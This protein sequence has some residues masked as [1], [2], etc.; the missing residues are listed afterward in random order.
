MIVTFNEEY[1]RDIYR[2]GVCQDKR[3]LYQPDIIRRYRKAVAYMMA[4]SSPEALWKIHSLNFEALSGQKSGTFSVRVN[5]KYRIEFT[6][7]RNA[8]K[9][10]A[11][12]CNITELSNHYKD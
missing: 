1:L 2:D 7:V 6:I 8:D 3:H 5:D 11:T 4:A 10:S 12:I 9:P